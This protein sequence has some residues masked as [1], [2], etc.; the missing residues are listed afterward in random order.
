MPGGLRWRFQEWFDATPALRNLRRHKHAE[1]DR[2]DSELTHQGR[3]TEPHAATVGMSER[4]IEIPWV[5]SRISAEQAVLDV[6]TSNAYTTYVRHLRAMKPKGL[7]ALDLVHVD[8]GIPSDRG[9]MRAMPYADASF[10]LVLCVSTLEHVGMD[11]TGYGATDSG[12][13]GDLAAL[14][15]VRR[16]LKPEGRL[17]VTVPFGLKENHGWF[18]QYDDPEWTEL[19]NASGLLETERQTY[20]YREGWSLGV[21]SVGYGAN[22]APGAAGVLCAELTNRTMATRP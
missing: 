9:D 20:C 3:W 8:R 12:D 13:G 16:I 19:V 6:G 21:P 17:L 1:F 7:R 2:I 10:D 18:H 4:V 5:L 14:R 11:N 15:D 22:Q